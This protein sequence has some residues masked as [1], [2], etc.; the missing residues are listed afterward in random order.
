MSERKT[1][2][3]GLVLNVTPGE[4]ISIGPNIKISAEILPRTQ[5]T[6]SVVIDAPRSI[7]VSRSRYNPEVGV[8]TATK[9]GKTLYKGNLK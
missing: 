4:V 8:I 3:K 9:P 7:E 1:P 2:L 5:D 6:I